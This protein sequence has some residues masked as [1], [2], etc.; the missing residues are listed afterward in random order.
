MK[1]IYKYT[2][3]SDKT[4]DVI[5]VPIGSVLLKV[6]EQKGK[7]CAWFLVEVFDETPE[8]TPREQKVFYIVCTGSAID[9]NF[10]EKNVKYIDTIIL[11][12]LVYHIFIGK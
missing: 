7:I 3:S 5:N 10:Q 11:E 6:H 1:T 2:L 4:Y 9:D 8:E 12:N